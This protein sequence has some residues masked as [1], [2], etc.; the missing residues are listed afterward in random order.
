MDKLVI[1]ASVVVKWFVVEAHSSEA[2]RLLD[3]YQDGTVSFH[4]PDLLVAELANTIWKKQVFQGLTATEAK[5]ILSAFV[6]LQVALIPAAELID[7]AYDLAVDN[8]R[9]VY[10]A[11]YLA[12]SL[13]ER[14]PL[15]TADERFVNAMA[16]SYPQVVWVA[17]WPL[18]ASNEA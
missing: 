16:P 17:N 9:S 13:R 14:C 6:S 2:R 8:R 7:S 3:A 1:D 4:A 18:P 12:L 15:I 10:D 11:L 5:E